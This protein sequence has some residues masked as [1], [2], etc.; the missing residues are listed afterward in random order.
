[1][2]SLNGDNGRAEAPVPKGMIFNIMRFSVSD[3]PGI[4]TTMFMKGCSLRCR[5][6]HNPEA[7]ASQPEIIYRQERC[8][9]CG[10]CFGACPHSAIVPQDGYYVTVRQRCLQCGT[11]VEVCVSDAREIVGKE[12]T[13]AEAMQEIERDVI[14]Y[15]ES[16]GGVTF[17]G[18][19][20]LLQHQFLSELL[21][22][23]KTKNI[24]TAID[25]SGFADAEILQEISHHTDLFLYDLKVLDD[26]KHTEFT[27]V[28]NGL[29]LQ[30]L[31][32]LVRWGKHVI[33]RVPII[34][35]FNDD[36]ADIT[37]LGRFV[38]GLRSIK[39]IQLLP[40]HHSGIA[41]YER[42]G[43]EYTMPAVLP[44][45]QQQLTEI[46]GQLSKYGITTRIGG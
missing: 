24:H 16:G 8:V 44:P 20:P 14:F 31:V 7:V 25:T 46:A 22:A 21:K 19:E 9:R 28:S 13:V 41:K 1:M 11:C 38:A 37:Q 10:D 2:I 33:V 32:R 5:W 18:G 39:E 30:N 23:C 35:G 29:I 3:G 26:A 12:M 34:P 27:G 17:S 15:D 42:L 43:K 4:R 36:P 40:F 45:S 6:C